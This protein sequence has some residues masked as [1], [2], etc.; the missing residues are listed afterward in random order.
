MTK[1]VETKMYRLID[2]PEKD[3]STQ[4]AVG[5]ILGGLIGAAL[6]GPI[7]LGIGALIGGVASCTCNKEHE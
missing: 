4:V 7:G 6:G 3:D 1:I 5:S 2:E